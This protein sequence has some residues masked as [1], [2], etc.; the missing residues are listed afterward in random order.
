MLSHRILA[1]NRGE[2][3]NILTISLKFEDKDREFI[4]NFILNDFQNKGLNELHKK[5]IIDA[6]DRLI[7]PS[8]EREV[9]NVLT[10]MAEKEAIIIFKENLKN[11]LMQ[12]PLSNKNILALDP[13]YRTGCK[14][15]VIDKNGF[16]K[17]N[18]VLYVVKEMHNEN[19]LKMA[20]KK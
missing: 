19:Q 5:I 11:L 4:E 7:L 15:A 9:R 16:F 18:T 12:P 6:L 3:E 8:I 13:G 20:D 14:V 10:E 17:E 2:K 1:I